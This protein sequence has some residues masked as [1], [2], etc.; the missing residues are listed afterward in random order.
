MLGR[1]YEGQNCSVAKTLELVG[2]RWTV[3]ILR[4]VYFG[5]RRF[6]EMAD[7]L[8]IARNVL[9]ARLQRLIDE[10]VLDKVAYQERPTRFEYRLTEKGLDLWP[11]LVTLMQYGDRYY[12]PDGPPVVLTHRDCGGT[13][14]VHRICERC[15]ARLT[16]RDVRAHAGPGATTASAVPALASAPARTG[17]L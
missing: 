3:L 5:R 14:D 6:D 15:G 1:T 16:A 11:V 9:T 4:E 13:L 10:D 17:H 12:A 8:G 2:E 7:N